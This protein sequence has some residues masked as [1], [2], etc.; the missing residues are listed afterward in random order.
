MQRVSLFF[1]LLGRR[2]VL[3]H[4]L[5]HHYLMLLLFCFVRQQVNVVLLSAF[6]PVVH[7]LAEAAVHALNII[8][9]AKLVKTIRRP[10]WCKNCKVGLLARSEPS[11]SH[12]LQSRLS[13]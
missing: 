9:I 13:I 7:G 6:E 8:N 10:I 2:N 5:S 3:D 4:L 11:A 12:S 1:Y